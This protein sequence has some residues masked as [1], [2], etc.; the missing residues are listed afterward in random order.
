M[1]DFPCNYGPHLDSGGK[2]K[3]FFK[4]FF[5]NVKYFG[6]KKNKSSLTAH[7]SNYMYIRPV[8]LQM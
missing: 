5:Q 6:E 8:L 2:E 7:C 3:Y 1:G 4:T